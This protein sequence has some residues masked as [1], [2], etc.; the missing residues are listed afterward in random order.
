MNRPETPQG[1][2]QLAPTLAEI[3][4]ALLADGSGG[5]DSAESVWLADHAAA[6]A[7]R[8]GVAEPRAALSA[9]NSAPPVVDRRLH[10]L[11]VQQRLGLAETLALALAREAELLPM[12]ARALIWLQHPVGEARPTVGLIAS[13]CQRLGVADALPAL[14]DGPARRHGLL[15]LQPDERP[16][17][18]RSVRVGLPLLFAIDG[19]DGHFDG[20]DTDTAA[21]PPLPPSTVAEARRHG[22][23][24][25]RDGV[26]TLLIRS[27]QPLEARAAAAQVVGAMG[28]SAAFFEGEAAPGFAAWLWQIGRAHV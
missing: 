7:S 5:D 20:V 8:P 14:A 3:A 12:A 4:F 6:L 11:A 10:A 13:L 22:A 27:G 25:I 19:R 16:L 23:G 24:L 21:L 9:W 28:A 18:E 17:C 15:Q 1:G 2:T 26:R